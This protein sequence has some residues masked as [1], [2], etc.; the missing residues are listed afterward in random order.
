MTRANDERAPLLSRSGTASGRFPLSPATLAKF[1]DPKD[2]DLLQ[3]VGGTD[4]LLA[5]LNVDPSVGLPADTSSDEYRERVAAYGAN[6]L[7]EAPSKSFFALVAAAFE[8]K[9]LIM[10]SIAAVVSLIVGVYDDYWGEKRHEETKIGWVEGAAILAAVTIVVLTTAVN[11]WQK[12]RQFRKLNAKKEDRTVKVLRGGHER[13]LSVFDV[14]VGDIFL[15]EPG[16]IAPVDGVVLTAQNL[17]CDESSATGESDTIRKV[18]LESIS[19]SAENKKADPFILSGAK[20]LEGVGRMVVIAVGEQSFFG[21]MMMALRVDDADSAGAQATPLQHKLDALAE[22][23]ARFGLGASLLMLITLIIKMFVRAALLPEFP[24]ASHLFSETIK[25]VV[26][27]ITIVVVAVPEGLPMAVT[28]ALAYATTQMLRDNNLVRQLSACETSGGLTTVCSDKTGTLTMNQMTVVKAI[29]A[30]HRLGDMEDAHRFYT[31][32]L[33]TSA[34]TILGEAIAVNSTA[35]ED[36]D[37]GNNGRTVFVGSKTEAAL[38]GFAKTCG[39]DYNGIR[40][41]SNVIRAYPFA[42]ELKTMTTVVETGDSKARQHTKGAS[43]IVLSHCSQYVDS[44]GN[45]QQLTESKRQDIELSISKFAG[46]AL[47]TI[48]IAYRDLPVS[49]AS[50]LAEDRPPLSDLIWLGLTG[51]E[52]PLRPGVKESVLHCQGAGVTVRMITGDNLETARAIASKA[53]IYNRGGACVTGPEFRAMSEKQQLE[54]MPNLQVLARSSPTDKQ[55]V[56]RRLQALGEVVGMSGDGTNDAPALRMADVG[57]AMGIAGTEVAKSAADIIL[58]DDNFVSVVKAL[59]WGR[60]INDSVR[61]FVQFQLTANVSAVV[62]TFISSVMSA[63]SEGILTSTQMLFLNICMDSLAA[64]GLS[65]EP[66]TDDLLNRAPIPKHAA[67]LT[68][69]M[70]RMVFGQALFQVA[71]NLTLLHVG[72]TLFHLPVDTDPQAELVMR[73]MVFNTFIFLQVFNMLNSRRID[74]SLNIFANITHD[75]GFLAIFFLIIG[76]QALII[77]F[78]GLAFSTT[79]LTSS[80]W[81]ATVLLGSLALPIGFMIR[82]LPD[83]SSAFGVESRESQAHVPTVTREDMQLRSYF[84]DVHQSMQV[85]NALQTF[86]SLRRSRTFSNPKPPVIQPSA[87]ST[88][89]PAPAS[90]SA[91]SSNPQQTASLAELMARGRQLQ[92]QQTQAQP[93]QEAA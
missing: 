81:T 74:S 70:W 75:S 58:M 73:T 79:P 54:L 5:K 39:V 24:T 8:D 3:D 1:V 29:V 22:K 93:A 89:L 27:S 41:R 32:D 51:I 65:T 4:A 23:I 91:A 21:K 18:P 14:V 46:E 57:L 68:F 90:S 71:L 86:S 2:A 88:A 20:V 31:Q 35:F 43:E 9:I 92:A 25:I 33:P 78:G 61:K 37:E 36:K 50:S 10:L 69:E 30:E 80:Q 56:T 83:W 77:N 87:S 6:V 11:D 49:E 38:L 7:P 59:R 55:I 85:S 67:L 76:M 34:S 26:Q 40:H 72:P 19:S 15:I 42:S 48:G 12:E 82:L 62:L 66:P 17:K 84:A 45:V 63:S 47:R 53:G 52:D 64:V 16:E 13:L 60:A 28:L 44:T